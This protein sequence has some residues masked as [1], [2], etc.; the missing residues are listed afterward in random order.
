MFPA[1]GGTNRDNGRA[2]EPNLDVPRT[3]GDE[4]EITKV[5]EADIESF[6]HS[7]G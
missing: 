6:L 2:G 1:R 7:R 3:R 5:S 4:P